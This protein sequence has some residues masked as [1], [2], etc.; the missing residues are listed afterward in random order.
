MTLEQHEHLRRWYR[1]HG[2][3]AI[4][5]A[6]WNLVVTFWLAA[7]VGEPIAWLLRWDGTALATLPLLFAPGA[8]VRLRLRLHRHGRLR[9]D[10]AGALR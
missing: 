2:G 10:W 7:W 5:Y 1:H 4:E 9:C 3:H 8:Y 6:V